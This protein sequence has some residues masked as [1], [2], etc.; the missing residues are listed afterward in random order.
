MIGSIV[1]E[2]VVVRIDLE[3]V[4]LVVIR[5]TK[6]CEMDGMVICALI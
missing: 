1:G 3:L 2:E 5:R 6:G 4:L